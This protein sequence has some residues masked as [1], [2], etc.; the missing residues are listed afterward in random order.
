MCA[1]V[2]VHVCT[3]SDANESVAINQLNL[4]EYYANYFGNL[5]FLRMKRKN[6]SDQLKWYASECVFDLYKFIFNKSTFSVRLSF[7]AV[8]LSSLLHSWCARICVWKRV[9]SLISESFG[10]FRSELHDI[11]GW[12]ILRELCHVSSLWLE[13]RLAYFQHKG[14]HTME[15]D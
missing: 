12:W 2:S 7:L 11:L 1:C 3:F 6:T 8:L 5:P 15:I 10:C 14:K 13:T 4:F 9:R